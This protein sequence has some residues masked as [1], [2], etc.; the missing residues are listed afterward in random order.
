MWSKPR[1]GKIRP[2]Q[3]G[4]VK[5][6]GSGRPS[7]GFQNLSPV[8]PVDPGGLVGRSRWAGP[9]TGQNGPART[10]PPALTLWPSRCAARTNAGHNDGPRT[11]P[12]CHL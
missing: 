11:G 1:G 12:F 3:S 8:R 2:A 5:E 6:S 9:E 10:G 4:P 7:P